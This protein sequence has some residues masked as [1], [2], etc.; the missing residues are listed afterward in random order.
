MR[1][2]EA[3]W[4]TPLRNPIA[5]YYFY[6]ADMFYE[7]KKTPGAATTPPKSKTAPTITSRNSTTSCNG[8]GIELAMARAL[9]S[10]VFSRYSL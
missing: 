10:Q 4:T 3:L 8:S 1:L 5:R 2:G 6:S 7:D 9:P